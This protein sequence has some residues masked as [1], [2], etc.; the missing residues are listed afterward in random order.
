MSKKTQ[1]MLTNAYAEKTGLRSIDILEKQISLMEIF[2]ND[3]FS[4][5]ENLSKS[6]IFIMFY[7][8]LKVIYM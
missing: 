6:E 8:G 3:M 4:K 7:E 2:F 5:G 1:N